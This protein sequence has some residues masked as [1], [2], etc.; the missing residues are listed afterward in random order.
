[1][2]GINGLARL[3]GLAGPRLKHVRPGF[4]P[5]T[6]LAM[7]SLVT[8]A[9][10]VQFGHTP[11]GRNFKWPVI[12]EHQLKAERMLAQIPP[13]A[14][15]AAQNIL[16]PHLSQRQWIF[17]IPKLAQ[18]DKPADYI[19]LDMTSNPDPYD[20]VEEYCAVVDQLLADPDYGLVVADDGL[21]LFQRGVPDTATF[22]PMALCP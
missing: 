13:Q 9:Y 2:A 5:A 4:L 8:L 3:I 16:V 12:A 6:L 17:I 1:V 22:T 18:R 10:Q 15:V 19:A 7:V 11:I 14:A 20:S 21:L